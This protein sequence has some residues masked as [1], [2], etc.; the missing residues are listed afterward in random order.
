MLCGKHAKGGTAIDNS[1]YVAM[2][3]HWET[4]PFD[5]PGL[6]D[7]MQWHVFVNTMLPHPRI[8]GSLAAEPLLENQSRFLVGGG[9]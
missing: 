7:G 5:L 4:L 8:A 3:M 9:R 2:N 6:R 1:I